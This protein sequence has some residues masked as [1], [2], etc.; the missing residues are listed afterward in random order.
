MRRA[1]LAVILSA[2]ACRQAPPPVETVVFHY[3]KSVEGV[4]RESTF[5]E[6]PLRGV[7]G[8]GRLLAGLE[9]ALRTMKPGEEKVVAL[10]PEKAH[11]E[12]DPKNVSVMPV[13]DFGDM[14]PQLV[15]GARILGMRDGQSPE[16]RRRE[17]RERQGD[18]GFQPARRRQNR[19]LP[20][21]AG[22][23]RAR[24]APGPLTPRFGSMGR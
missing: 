20:P 5:K 14:A 4:V 15:P 3:E 13:A 22:L 16:S 8:E 23:A 11:G 9:E 7:L 24:A 2:A 6:L 17:G 18:L 21:P 10:A 19:D 12:R 1:L